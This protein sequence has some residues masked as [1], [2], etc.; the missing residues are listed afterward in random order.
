MI[1]KDIEKIIVACLAGRWV[2][3]F[4]YFFCVCV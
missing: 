1:I 4:F 3:D 2:M